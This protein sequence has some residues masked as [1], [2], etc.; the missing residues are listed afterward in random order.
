L[1]M[2]RSF[3]E[4]PENLTAMHIVCSEFSSRSLAELSAEHWQTTL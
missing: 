2:I 3:V 4:P 1:L